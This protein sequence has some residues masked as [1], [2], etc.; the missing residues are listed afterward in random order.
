MSNFGEVNKQI[1]IFNMKRIIFFIAITL[2]LF[3]SC[4]RK[5]SISDSELIDAKRA[6]VKSQYAISYADIDLYYSNDYPELYMEQLPYDL[7]MCKANNGYACYQFYKNYL[8]ISNS[9][10]FDKLY[11]SKLDTQEQDF[12][13]YILNKGASQN[14]YYCRQYLYYYYKNGIVVEKDSLKADSISRFFPKG[15]FDNDNL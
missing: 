8:K 12:L 11:I 7:I 5:S 10:K 13:L 2:F 4:I 3:I 9:G 1:K 14:E 15:F 6:V